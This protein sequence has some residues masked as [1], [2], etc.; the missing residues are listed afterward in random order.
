[1]YSCGLNAYGELGIDVDQDQ[2]GNYVGEAA[3]VLKCRSVPVQL[4]F[5]EKIRFIAAGRNHSLAISTT[6]EAGIFDSHLYSWGLSENGQLGHYDAKSYNIPQPRR[7][8]FIDAPGTKIVFASASLR[9]TLALDT[10]GQLWFFGE[11][12]SVGI[13][14]RKH[15]YQFAP[16]RLHASNA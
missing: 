12:E 3:L 14:D 11:K 6:Q 8:K 15:K 16:K 10:E 5:Y 9:H 7:V 1:M 2:G 13:T 4:N